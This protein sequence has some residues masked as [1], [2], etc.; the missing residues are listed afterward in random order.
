MAVKFIKVRPLNGARTAYVVSSEDGV[1]L[2]SVARFGAWS[3][4][5]WHAHFYDDP[6]FVEVGRFWTRRAA[7]EELADRAAR[8]EETD[9]GYD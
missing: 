9:Y 4:S 7:A 8:R 6:G 5:V 2:G 3:S 1:L